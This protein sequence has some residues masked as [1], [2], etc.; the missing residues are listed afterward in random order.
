MK[1]A[2]IAGLA[3]LSVAFASGARPAQLWQ[4][5][6]ELYP[7]NPAQRQALDECFALDV[8][9]DRLDPAARDACYQRT[10]PSLA[11]ADAGGQRRELPHPAGNF[12]DLWRAAGQGNLPQNDIRAEQ[13]NDA[14]IHPARR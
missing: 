2:V 5:Y 13:R 14:Y 3:G 12:V 9:F 4:L 10:L 8:R 11:L 6:Q 7:S 1:L